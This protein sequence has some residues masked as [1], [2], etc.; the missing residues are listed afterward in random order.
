MANILFIQPSYAHYRRGL[1]DL[2]HKDHNVTFVFLRKKS[3]YPSKQSTNPDWDMIFIEKKRFWILSLIKQIYHQ[4]PQA[5]ITSING[6]YQSI[7]SIFLGKLYKI[8]VILW[9]LTW[10]T[11]YR[12]DRPYWKSLIQDIRGKF[13]V[14][15][16][17][18]LVVS[19]V[20]SK[21]FNQ[22]IA[23]DDKPIFVA[24]QST[25][26]QSLFVDNAM[27][28]NS[29]P[30][31]VSILYF[32]RIIQLKGLD[33]L[34]RAFAE[35]EQVKQNVRLSIAGD[36]PF[37]EYCEKLARELNVQN[38]M[39]WGA[40]ANE[41]AW[42]YYFEAD[43]FVLPNSGRG[44]TDAWGL[45]INE[46]ASMS[47]PIVTTDAVGATG[48]LVKDGLNGYV[49]RAGDVLALRSALEKL[50]SDKSKREKM[51]KESRKLF[52]TINN[53]NRM[54]NGFN[55]AIKLVTEKN[56]I[57]IFSGFFPAYSGG[58][59]YQA[60][61]L[62]NVL[63]DYGHDVFFTGIGG[64][65]SG[66]YDL[67]GFR[68]YF[69]NTNR[70][71]RK[72]GNCTFLLYPQ[73]KKILSKEKPDIVY[74][75]NGSAVPGILTILKK[76]MK[77]KFI[78]GIA[79]D[80][81]LI[82]SILSAGFRPF[83]LI[84]HCLRLYGMNNADR[85]IAQ[86]EYQQKVLSKKFG[87]E[88]L[89]IRNAHPIPK[90]T[91]EKSREIFKVLFIAN[92]KPIK[93]PELYVKL[94][95]HFKNASF[96][97]FIMIGR[98][99][100]DNAWQEKLKPGIINNHNL[101]HMGELSQE[102]VNKHLDKAH[103]LVNTST[104]EGFSNTFIQAWMRK[105]PVISLSVDP[106]NLLS[107]KG[108]GLCSG[109]SFEHLVHDVKRLVA[110]QQLRES[111]GEKA[112]DYAFEHHSIE[113]IGQQF[114]KLVGSLTGGAKGKDKDTAGLSLDQLPGRDGLKYR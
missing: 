55:D 68:V 83:N 19:G 20:R 78:Y 87:I 39:F 42:K 23:Q 85:V 107:E 105:V 88:S 86:T 79:S 37:R 97:Q 62:A 9:S 40:V 4:K 13:T 25:V 103:I 95:I 92:Y 44:G 2:L 14:R 101:T 22:H 64:H 33:I 52:E 100:Y 99:G 21:K 38:I 93:R 49:V 61:L 11:P 96:V 17:D 67:E 59:E 6:S 108:L 111:M 94:A 71:L 53:Y 98:T 72:L 90:D 10:T 26:D 112:R 54:Y 75:R 46:A 15:C 7:I 70:A 60:Y 51:G 1:F 84:D 76:K 110:D 29:Y 65:E 69:L 47:L 80:S 32:S 77:Y 57:C 106:D 50:L 12:L 113:Q 45:V 16:A 5:I 30:K 48:E 102:E 82:K 66:R 3:T 74:S 89:V 36:G 8:S 91:G 41:D 73:I 31:N 56:K 24:Y 34:I 81:S 104:S 28:K 35:L 58:A 43:I 63:R 18:A 109:G 27:Q 114:S